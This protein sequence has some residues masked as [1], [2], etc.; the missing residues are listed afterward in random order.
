MYRLLEA[1]LL[2]LTAIWIIYQAIRRLLF[3][4][5]HDEITILAL[6]VMFV[7][8]AVDVT[9]SRVLLR[10]ARQTG[11]QTLQ[12][13][14]LYFCTDIVSSSVVIA[15]L[16]VVCLTERFSLPGWIGQA[17]VIVALGVSGIVIWVSMLLEKETMNALLDRAPETVTQQVQAQ[18]KGLA[19]VIEVRRVR[20]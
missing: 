18:I 1:G 8:L 9:Q 12:A 5:S 10:V 2:I 20:M 19:D 4:N 14:A 6:L 3:L 17:D 7:T 16:L 15:G 11:R 13:E